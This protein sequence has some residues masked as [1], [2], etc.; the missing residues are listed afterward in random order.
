MSRSYILDDIIMDIF[1]KKEEEE[2]KPRKKYIF[3]N[4]AQQYLFIQPIT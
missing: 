2:N 4:K 1:E 3:K